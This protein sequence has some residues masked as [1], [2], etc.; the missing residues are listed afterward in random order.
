MLCKRIVLSLGLF[1]VCAQ[2]H[3]GDANR[4]FAAA[5]GG[6]FDKALTEWTPL[7]E[8]GFARAQYNVGVMHEMGE[9]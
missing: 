6:D 5:Q 3:A 8:Q 2:G 1:F 4:A 9:G 7:A